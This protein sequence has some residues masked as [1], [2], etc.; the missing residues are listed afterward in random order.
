[1]YPHL[2]EAPDVGRQKASFNFTSDRLKKA[3]KACLQRKFEKGCKVH[4]ASSFRNACNLQNQ[5]F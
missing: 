3:C 2:D 4:I 5:L 1:M